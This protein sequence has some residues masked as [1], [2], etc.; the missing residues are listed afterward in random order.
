MLHANDPLVIAG[1]KIFKNIPVI[2]LPCTGFIPARVIT[3]ME[4]S[5]LVP[6][7]VNVWNEV[8]LSD[9]LMVDIIHYFNCRAVHSLAYLICLRHSREKQARMVMERIKRLYDNGHAF[10]FS[11]FSTVFQVFDD[12]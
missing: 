1:V 9:L 2:D 11:Y 10:R 6:A 3:A 8:T 12:V 7:R 4:S 5:Y